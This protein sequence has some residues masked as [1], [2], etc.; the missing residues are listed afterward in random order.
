MSKPPRLVS[1]KSALF[2]DSDQLAELS[3]AI[4][5]L[6]AAFV[7]LAEAVRDNTAALREKEDSGGE[8]STMD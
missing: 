2:M 1:L 5:G 8:E 7:D 3:E 4:R 6:T